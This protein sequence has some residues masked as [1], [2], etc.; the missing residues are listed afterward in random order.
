MF[1]IYTLLTTLLLSAFFS[2]TETALLGL[3]PVNIVRG[4][5]QKLSYLYSK[6]EVLIATCLIG[7]NLTIVA[8][9]ISLDSLLTKYSHGI[10]TS[11][12]AFTIQILIFFFMAELLPKSVFRK[13]GSRVLEFFYY[14]LK[15]FYLV[16]S[17][18]S[19]TF[20]KLTEFF[21]KIFPRRSRATNTQVYY[22]IS[23]Q[24]TRE[25]VIIPD[26]ILTMRKTKAKEVMTPLADVFSLDVNMQVKN[27]LPLL[28]QTAYSRYPVYE[29]RGDNITGYISIYDLLYAKPAEKLA[30]YVYK[31]SYVPEPVTIDRIVI[32]M[33][34]ENLPMVFVV[35]EYGAV[36]GLITL[37]NIAEE[38][39]GDIRT[40]EQKEETPDIIKVKPRTYIL[41]GNLDIDDF[42]DRF[43]LNIEKHDFETLNGY[44][45]HLLDR[46][47]D[48]NEKIKTDFGE[49][50]IQKS[51][52]KSVEKVRLRLK[53]R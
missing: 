42:N 33:Q 20:L 21:Q 29:N 30:N 34:N 13:L 2:G 37:E 10:I 16:F 52:K 3:N 19:F 53:N 47:P 12:I 38:L 11:I 22:F 28:E 24:F 17:P 45:I 46:I 48:D 5:R 41:D 18:L 26:G 40:I 7:N 1:E 49:F 39:V 35:S 6:R 23:S 15:L 50:F 36:T 51:D 14:L 27:I 4:N 8:A 44:L 25:E 32:N 43:K 31:A 9:T